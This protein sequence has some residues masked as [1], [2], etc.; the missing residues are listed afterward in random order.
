MQCY[1]NIASR[2]IDNVGNRLVERLNHF[3]YLSLIVHPLKQLKFL[4][5]FT[6]NH[7]SFLIKLDYTY[8][9]QWHPPL[10]ILDSFIRNFWFLSRLLALWYFLV[11]F[12]QDFVLVSEYLHERL[13]DYLSL[14]ELILKYFYWYLVHK[15]V[16]CNTHRYVEFTYLINKL[17]CD[18][19]VRI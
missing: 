16:L 3:R 1:H 14:E 4:E 7:H 5:H 18:L 9:L 17:L 12:K 8:F 13:K 10:D 15:Y 11:F 6:S 2:D 19:L